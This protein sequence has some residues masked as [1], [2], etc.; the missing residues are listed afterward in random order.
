MSQLDFGE[1]DYLVVEP[2]NM[3]Q[4]EIQGKL[5]QA[6]R[7]LKEVNLLIEQSQVEVS[8]LTQRNTTATGILTRV[9]S[10][11]DNLPREE[12]RAAYDA[13]LDA[14][15]RLFL[16]RGQLEKLQTDQAH[17]GFLIETLESIAA[18]LGKQI[19]RQDTQQRPAATS[20]LLEMMIQAQ[21]A[22]RQK[23]SRQMHDGPAQALSNLILEADIAMRL[24]EID[25]EKAYEEL[26]VLK[27]SAIDTFQQVKDFIF[28]L[29]PMILDDLGLVPTVKKYISTLKEQHGVEIQLELM[30]SD[31]RLESY[32]ELMIF[33]AIQEMLGNALT[34][35]Q[36]TEIKLQLYIDDRSVR[37]NVEDNGVGFDPGELQ[38][39]QG[40]GLKVIRERVEMIGGSFRLDSQIG[41]GTSVGFQVPASF[42]IGT[43]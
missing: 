28:E 1:E 39:R 27:N 29:R 24:F 31:L 12:I 23:L 41:G 26:N 22:E 32:L 9:H 38:E 30:G 10:Q 14:Q 16:M 18:H 13:A 36:A 11:F 5:D 8:K 2:K 25:K 43:D 19:A 33:R 7:Q 40:M 34:H 37:V 15:Q 17:L 21:E 42:L 20:E 3:L 4:Q 6:R 35:S